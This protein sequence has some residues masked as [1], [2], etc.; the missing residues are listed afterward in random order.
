MSKFSL[1]YNSSSTSTCFTSNCDSFRSAIKIISV[2]NLLIFK[3]TYLLYNAMNF[4]ENSN[5]NIDLPSMYP[6]FKLDD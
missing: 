1:T 6:F 4:N 3:L 2:R 5:I